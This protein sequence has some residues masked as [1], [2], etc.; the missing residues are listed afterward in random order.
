MSALFDQSYIGTANNRIIFNDASTHPFFRVTDTKVMNRQIR[1][2]DVPIPGAQGV[3]DFRTFEGKSYF[4][5]EGMMYPSG[6][7]E[8]YTGR[9]K[10][11]QLANLEIAQNDPLSDGGYVP[12][13]WNEFGQNRVLYV[14]VEYADGLGES[15]NKGYVQPFRLYCKVKNPVIYSLD[16]VTTTLN[17]PISGVSV[18]A[19]S[20]PLMY[21]VLYGRETY[22]SNGSIYN[23]GTLSSYPAI[24]ISGPVNVPRITNLTT[25]EYLEVNVN[26]PTTTDFLTISYDQDTPPVVTW[27]GTSYY[28]K[29]S[30]GSTF[31]K[32]K[33]GANQLQLTGQSLST[34]ASA[35]VSAYSAYPLS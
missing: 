28:N 15:T 23:A 27:G 32:L 34:N 33:A 11:R 29:V 7:A 18:G 26:L 17:V 21:P 5:I 3:A 22:S 30:A 20:Y 24:L 2:Q 9:D 12:Y 10:L 31:F 8:Y 6:E 25:G 35:T 14:L 16:A 19:S 4:V 1:E 13:V